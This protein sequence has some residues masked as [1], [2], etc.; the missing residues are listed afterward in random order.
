MTKVHC[1]VEVQWLDVGEEWQEEKPKRKEPATGVW[2]IGPRRRYGE[3]S[4]KKGASKETF[5]YPAE[6]CPRRLEQ[7]PQTK[8][9]FTGP[10]VM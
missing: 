6:S 10:S 9:Q 5:G 4:A 7:A 8:G 3:G 2:L 1:G